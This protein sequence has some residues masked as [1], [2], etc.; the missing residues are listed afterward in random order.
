M[1]NTSGSPRHRRKK[2]N[3]S[4]DIDDD[5]REYFYRHFGKPE[6]GTYRP[7]LRP[8]RVLVWTLA[9]IVF[10]L[11]LILVS[12]RREKSVDYTRYAYSLY[13]TDT[14]TLCNALMVFEA[15]KRYGS[16]ADRILHYPSEWD[17]QV[18]N[19][20]DRNSQLLISMRDDYKVKLLPVELLGANG[21]VEPGSLNQEASWDASIT[22]LLA[23]ELTT[24]ERILHLDSDV[25][26]LQ[27]LDELFLLPPTPIAMPRAYWAEVP[28]PNFQGAQPWPLTSLLVLLKPS[29]KDFKYMLGVLEKWREDAEFGNIE[30]YDMDLLNYRYGSSAMVLPQ[31]PY[32]LLSSE[33]RRKN[34]SAYLGEPHSMAHWDPDAALKEAKLVHFSDWPLPKP[35]TMWSPEALMDIQPQCDDLFGDCRERTIWKNL[36]DD[37]RHR[38]KDLCKILSTAAPKWDQLKAELGFNTSAAPIIP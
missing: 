4:F 1:S 9:A 28:A 18:H 36:Y 14:H 7:H 5:D 29:A 11:L 20:L 26:L 10:F 24:Y 3:A 35:W 27:H 37:F 30:K 19:E 21:P 2:S 23:F 12:G 6:P 16:K 15:L 22:K 38:R 34:H 13:A 32:A 17:T 25:T 8:S 33:F 31:R